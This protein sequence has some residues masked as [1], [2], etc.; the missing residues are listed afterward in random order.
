MLKAL[1]SFLQ[2]IGPKPR[3]PYQQIGGEEGL[4][5]LV[6]DFYEIMDTAA[7]ARQCRELHFESLD[8]AREKLFLFLSG[9]LGGPNLYIEKFGH[10]RMRKR[11]FPFRITV[12]HRDQ[13]LWCMSEALKKNSARP[14]FKQT[15]LQSFEA[16]AEHMRNA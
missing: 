9:W 13:W 15:L 10:P 1:Q 11:H 5:K 14:K 3:T 2:K 16:F 6:V 12:I 8:E 4:R 7:E